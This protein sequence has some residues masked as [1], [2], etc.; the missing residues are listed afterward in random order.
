[1]RKTANHRLISA[2]LAYPTFYSKLYVDLR[3]ELTKQATAARQ[4]SGKGL[5]AQD[6]TQN[7]R[8]SGSSG[9]FERRSSRFLRCVTNY[10]VT[11]KDAFLLISR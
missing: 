1:M 6:V 5:F 9:D 7:G 4:G 3:Q 10:T 8:M 11:V 2:G